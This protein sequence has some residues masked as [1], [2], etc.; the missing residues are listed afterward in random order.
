MTVNNNDGNNDGM[1][2]DDSPDSSSG[3]RRVNNLPMIILGVVVI[4]FVIIMVMVGVDRASQSTSE[5]NKEAAGNSSMFAAEIAGDHQ[6]GLVGLDQNKEGQDEPIPNRDNLGKNSAPT[7]PMQP[8]VDEDARRIRMMKLQM[9]QQAALAKTGVTI[10]RSSGGGASGANP[11]REEM[12]AKIASVRQQIEQVKHEDPTKAYQLR[13]AQLQG[14]M[15]G[16]GMGGGGMGG[17]MG[18]GSQLPASSPG[19]NSLT[20]FQ[21]GEGDRWRLDSRSE[22]PRSPYE[23]RAGFVVPATLISG[24]NSDLPGQIIGQVAQ[25]VYDTPTG[26]HLL[27]PQGSRLVG[28]YESNLAISHVTFISSHQ[29]GTLGNQ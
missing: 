25:N 3:V 22:A 12:L 14:G 17:G 16:G 13:L 15:G 5:S 29:A 10:A 21:G 20:K 6:G 7:A 28:A 1:N 4:G 23:L 26:R 8:M 2:P 19:Q 18:G 27:I 24:I 11:S 9:L